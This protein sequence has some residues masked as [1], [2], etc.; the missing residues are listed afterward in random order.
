[1]KQHLLILAIISVL[2]TACTCGQTPENTSESTQALTTM[3]T[4]VP[5]PDSTTKDKDPY[6]VGKAFAELLQNGRIFT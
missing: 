5:V 6:D 2:V 3:V 1:M 4:D